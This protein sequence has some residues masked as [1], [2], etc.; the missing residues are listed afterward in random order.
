MNVTET[1]ERECMRMK[2]EKGKT[3][4]D[5]DVLERVHACVRWGRL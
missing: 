3:E 4:C 2:E 1:C 5:R